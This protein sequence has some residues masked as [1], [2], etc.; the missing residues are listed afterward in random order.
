MMLLQEGYQVDVSTYLSAEGILESMEYRG[1][2]ARFP[3]G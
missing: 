1:T 3:V 2:N